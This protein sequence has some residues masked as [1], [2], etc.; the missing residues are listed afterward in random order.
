METC[1]LCG[2]SDETVKTIPAIHDKPLC[3]HCMQE[4]DT[5]LVPIGVLEHTK[6]A[7]D[8]LRDHAETFAKYTITVRI[9]KT[10]IQTDTKI[11]E[12]H[13]TDDHCR[14]VSTAGRG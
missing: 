7:L 5:Q 4:A 13:Y 3:I 8:W 6:R 14:R 10:T 1:Y 11:H 9:G 12:F 2:I